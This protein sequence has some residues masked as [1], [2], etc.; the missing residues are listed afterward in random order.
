MTGREA[1]AHGAEAHLLHSVWT[2]DPWIVTPLAVAAFLYGRGC[3]R[4]RRRVRMSRSVV[5]KRA[6]CY[7]AGW[8]TL[9]GAL[10]SPLHWLGEQLFTFH[11]IE[12]E[13]IMAISAPMIVIARPA[14]TFLWGLPDRLTRWTGRA[15][16]R[17]SVRIAWHWLSGGT[18]ATLLHAVAIWA[19]HAPI[20]FDAAVADVTLHR[21][22]HLSF[23]AT[24][25]LFWWS[26]FWRSNRGVAAWHLFLTMLH[27]GALG[28]LMA[29]APRV[30]Y[31]AQTHTA[32]TWG[33]TPLEDQQLAGMVMWIPA[34]TIYAGVAL[35]MAA[36]WIANAGRGAD[37]VQHIRPL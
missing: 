10:L 27:T 15:M 16:R 22:Q 19:W 14:G 12:H 3:W 36:L 7:W 26:I 28:A 25:I 23:F 30:L 35:A 9:A 31:V 11:M 8:L 17:R 18:N 1:A 37:H 32:E 2:I 5:A 33:L 20:L 34:G 13:I 29:L 4:L 21:L 24:A 6:L